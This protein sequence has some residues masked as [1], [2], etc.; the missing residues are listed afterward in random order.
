MARSAASSKPSRPLKAVTASKPIRVRSP[1]VSF[2]RSRLE[3]ITTANGGMGSR[4]RAGQHFD[5]ALGTSKPAVGLRLQDGDRR[6]IL[7]VGGSDRSGRPAPASAAPRNHITDAAR[8]RRPKARKALTDTT[9]LPSFSPQRE[10][11]G[12]DVR[13]HG[14]SHIAG[15]RGERPFRLRAPGKVR[16]HHQSLRLA[17]LGRKGQRLAGE[18]QRGCKRTRRSAANGYRRQPSTRRSRSRGRSARRSSAR[19]CGS[20]GH[21]ERPFSAPPPRRT[22]GGR[23]LSLSGKPR[24]R[25]RA[26]RAA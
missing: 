9:G 18:P 19:E 22:T 4:D 3:S 14:E 2:A 11:L 5:H 10:R 20:P 26:M 21:F 23:P 25:D 7:D 16:G 17:I 13:T 6:R 15:S 12:Q 24:M 1:A 8:R